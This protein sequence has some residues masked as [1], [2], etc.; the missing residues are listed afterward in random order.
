[1][2]YG[3][4]QGGEEIQDGEREGSRQFGRNKGEKTEG[5]G[6]KRGGC[7]YKLLVTVLVWPCPEPGQVSLSLLSH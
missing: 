2:T 6:I 4:F 3:L 5:K 7:V 1:M